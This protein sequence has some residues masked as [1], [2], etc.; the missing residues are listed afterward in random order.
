MVH[1]FLLV[2]QSNMVGRDPTPFGFSPDP[3]LLNFTDGRGGSGPPG[4]QVATDPLRHDKPGVVWGTNAGRPFG[5]TLLPFLPPEDKILL[6]NRAWGGMPVA[7]W[8]PDHGPGGYSASSGY[9]LAVNPYQT[10]VED[11][12]RA[13]ESVHSTGDTPV[14]A[15]L[16]W[17]QGETDIDQQTD[18]QEYGRAVVAVLTSFRRDLR[19][20]DLPVV[21]FEVCQG[22]GGD[23]GQR[24]R[25]T[26]RRIAQEL[27][28]LF[29]T[30]DGAEVLADGVHLTTASHERLGRRAAELFLNQVR[31][32]SFSKLPDRNTVDP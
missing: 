4:L 29:V 19:T 25:A 1:V 17:F 2:G 14:P 22:Y 24:I 23:Q 31:S 12:A 21:L 20:P 5:W 28:A 26:Q 3:R 11:F 9:N 27:Q 30:S 8:Q 32:G 7:E 15:G 18:P 13:Q 6:V 16:L 10:A